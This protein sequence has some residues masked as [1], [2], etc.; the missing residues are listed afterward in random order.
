M[1]TALVALLGALY[2]LSAAPESRAQAP[3]QKVTISYSSSGITS[4]EFFIAKEKGFF[5]E[6]GLEPQLVQMSANAAIAAGITGDLIGLSSIGSAIRAIQRGAPLRALS[7]TLRRPLFW[8]IARPEYKSVKELKGKI[9]GIVTFGGSQHTA[10]RRLIALGGLDP[11]KDL[12]AIQAGE[13]SRQLQALATNAIQVSAIS[14]PWVLLGRDKFKMNILDSAI[15]KFASIQNGLA[16]HVR[17]LQEK[18]DL[19]TKIL[20][21]KAKAGR[22]FDQN[23]KEVS[24]ML[25]KMWNTDVAT[26]LE[27]YRMSKPAFTGSGIPSD[28]EIKEY[29]A[30]D[31]QIL[32]LSEPLAPS[33]VFDFALR[34]EV[35]RELGIK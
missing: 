35:N 3:L 23:E 20:R 19:V 13:E 8:M 29:L 24:Q 18:P 15:D 21:A 16:V 10:A 1:R 12:T 25:A 26:A 32:K 33:Q 9:M 28:E 22:Y 6:E 30:L 27:S 17:T 34:R 5:R 2:F 14:P 4:I 31:A 7:V 11:D